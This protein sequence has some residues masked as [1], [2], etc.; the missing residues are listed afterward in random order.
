MKLL[1]LPLLALLLPACSIVS[2]PAGDDPAKRS[3]ARFEAGTRTVLG[4][5][6]FDLVGIGIYL[7]SRTLETLASPV[8]P[9]K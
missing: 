7:P 9:S 6:L 3:T 2:E 4:I 8:T 5:T 1:L